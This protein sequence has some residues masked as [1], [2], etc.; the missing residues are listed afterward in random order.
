MIGGRLAVVMITRNRRAEALRSLGE[1]LGLPERPRVVLVDNDSRDGTAAAVTDAYP[2][3]EVI[4]LDRNLGGAARNV[5]VRAAGTR[6]VAF[7][8]DDSWWAPGSLAKA[9]A[10]LDRHPSVAVV[11]ARTLV[12]EEQRDDPLNEELARSPLHVAHDRPGPRVMGFLACA[13]VV[14]S[15]AFLDA[16]GFSAELLLGGEEQLLASDLAR[17]GWDLVYLPEAV[18]H[19]HPSTARSTHERR[20]RDLRNAL[21]FLWLRRPIPTALRRTLRLALTAP[22]DPASARGALDALRGLR[23]VAGARRKVPPGVERD[24]CLLDDR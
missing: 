10:V 6:Y 19:H 5:G 11:A 2:S 20:Q 12:G 14:R 22:R 3:V 21:W 23:W 9:A 8:D 24:L 18:A 17:D 4:R 13:A 15:A 7:S 1:L 16:G